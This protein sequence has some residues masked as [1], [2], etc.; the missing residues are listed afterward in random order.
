MSNTSKEHNAPK[1]EKEAPSGKAED[2]LPKPKEQEPEEAAPKQEVQQEEQEVKQEPK[3]EEAPVK[4]EE[5]SKIA[6]PEA[7]QV[8]TKHR[9]LPV[10]ADAPISEEAK[11]NL[12]PK[13]TVLIFSDNAALT[14]AYN[15][16]F[17]M[18][19]LK[20]HIFTKLK[21]RGKNVSMTSWDSLQETQTALETFAK[22]NQYPVQG[23]VYLLPCSLKK[24]DK[25]QSP[26]VEAEEY[27][28]PLKLAVK[29]F[30]KDL[31]D[32]TNADTFIATVF[33]SES[34]IPFVSKENPTNGTVLGTALCLRKEFYDNFGVL[35]KIIAF[36]KA[37]S[38]EVMA[39]KTIYEILKGDGRCLVGYDND[40]RHTLFYLPYKFADNESIS[41][42]G[43]TLAFTGAGTGFGA[44]LALKIAEKFKVRLILIGQEERLEKDSYYA[45]LTPAE[46]KQ[47]KEKLSKQLKE[48]DANISDDLISEHLSKIDN[49]VTIFKN[50][51]K[52]EA[53]GCDAEYFSTDFSNTAKLK[54][55][56]SKIRNRFGRVDGL[57]H[58]EDLSR[59]DFDSNINTVSNFL[60]FNFVKDGGIYLFNTNISSKLGFANQGEK[61]SVDSYLA[62]LAYTLNTLGFRA[63][64]VATPVFEENSLQKEKA[65]VL[66]KEL[67]T[68]LILEEVLYGNT[69]E[70]LFTDT[71]GDLDWDKQIRF[72]YDEQTEIVQ[73]EVKENKTEENTESAEIKQEE[74]PEAETE[75][76]TQTVP[77]EE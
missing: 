39:Q 74:H 5:P 54:E 37:I 53:L 64:S 43:K 35:A 12:S 24:Y 62:Q 19:G 61:A 2:P 40:N 55:T 68:D 33:E 70:V 48:Q 28:R 16:A 46:L 18:E 14:K 7:K 32:K 42:E 77:E 36:N 65:E 6:E 20:T 51:Q 71:L 75:E 69:A 66:S 52:F 67:C 26:A 15:D 17:K 41:L 38:A 34:G 73:E 59:K 29:I 56:I 21:T 57:F 47:E 27:L 22:E 13:R 44:S 9:F 10:L 25:K 3:Q 11:R 58:F 45:T 76:T 31:K 30:E 1:Q 8:N 4:E 50:L 49:S 60:A 63:L 72:D 23:I